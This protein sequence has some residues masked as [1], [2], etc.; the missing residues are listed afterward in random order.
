MALTR[1][2]PVA[3]DAALCRRIS[4]AIGG[5]DRL[6]ARPAAPAR[7]CR[8][9]APARSPRAIPRPSPMG[10][11]QPA[12]RAASTSNSPCSTSMLREARVARRRCCGASTGAPRSRALGAAGVAAAAR[13]RELSEALALL[14]HR[15]GAAGVACSTDRPEPAA[16]SPARPLRTLARCAGAVD[17]ARLDADITAACAARSRLVR[18]TDRQTGPPRRQSPARRTKRRRAAR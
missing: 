9:H 6:A 4:E 14:R 15:A 16:L 12:R 3:G 10:S 17:F 1:A 2:R 5:V 18:A 11:A 13:C 8:R 7:R